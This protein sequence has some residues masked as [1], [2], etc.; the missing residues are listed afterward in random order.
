MMFIKDFITTLVNVKREDLLDCIFYSKSDAS[1]SITFTIIPL[2][3][4]SCPICHN[5]VHI[6]G[7]SPITMNH[8]IFSNRKCDLIYKKRRYLCKNCKITFYQSYPAFNSSERTTFETKVN[9]LLDLKKYNE[10]YSSVAKRYHLSSTQ[11][12]RIFDKH[13]HIDRKPL[14]RV[15]S[16]DEVYFPDSTYDS[17]YAC[18]LM[19]F[20]TGVLI[21]F[22]T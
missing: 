16:M 18:V 7:Y 21:E 22:L 17:L 6:H 19:D 10:T 11:V 13:V 5:P 20:E 2:S 9:I 3:N 4:P 14:P 8:G 12:L 15:L 1:I